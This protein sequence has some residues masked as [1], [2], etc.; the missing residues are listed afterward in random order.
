MKLDA[1]ILV[2]QAGPVGGMVNA[3]R[4]LGGTVTAAVVG[5]RA[6][7]DLVAASGPDAVRWFAP[8]ET[9]A[10]EALAE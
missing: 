8:D 1:W 5:P 6:L 9:L 4:E 2:T 7:A 3:A 10:P